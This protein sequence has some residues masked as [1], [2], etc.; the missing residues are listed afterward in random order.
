LSNS[1]GLEYQLVNELSSEIIAAEKN[2]ITIKDILS[3]AQYEATDV[4]GV[5]Q[6][7]KD[8]LSKVSAL[9]LVLSAQRASKDV[10]PTPLP[11][12]SFLT[13]I[14][15]VLVMMDTAPQQNIGSLL[16]LAFATS[17]VKIENIMALLSVLKKS[18]QYIK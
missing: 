16:Q 18:I 4:K 15:F 7:F 9:F 8:N 10:K 17:S 14:D 6:S 1:N 11:I 3:D 5:L 2:Y 13:G 12:D